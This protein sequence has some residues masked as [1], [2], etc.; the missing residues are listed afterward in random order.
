MQLR[1]PYSEKHSLDE[2]ELP[3]LF[4]FCDQNGRGDDTHATDKI[5]ESE[6]TQ[7]KQ[8]ANENSRSEHESILNRSDPCTI[9]RD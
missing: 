6:V 7:I 8:A 3:V 2:E 1:D 9:S 4:A 5:G